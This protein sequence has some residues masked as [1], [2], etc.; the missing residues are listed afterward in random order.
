M[1][2]PER[3]RREGVLRQW[4]VHANISDEP[5]DCFCYSIVKK[6]S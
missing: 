2:K 5:R 3:G 1:S 6:G 4:V